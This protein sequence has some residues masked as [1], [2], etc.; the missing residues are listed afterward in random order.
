MDIV[1]FLIL[2]FG[3]FLAY[4]G[5]ERVQP[6]A[7]VFMKRWGVGLGLMV[8]AVILG[9]FLMPD[10]PDDKAVVSMLVV[11]G[12]VLCGMTTMLWALIRFGMQYY[13]LTQGDSK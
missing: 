8:F 2:A 1:M 10:G 6:L 12:I 4:F 11:G 9:G 5:T 3:A 7:K 13:T